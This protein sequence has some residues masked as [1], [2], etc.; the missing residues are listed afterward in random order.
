MGKTTARTSF[1]PEATVTERAHA[2]QGSLVR[3]RH[4]C[5]AG[6]AVQGGGADGRSA[7]TRSNAADAPTPAPHPP[8]GHT[9]YTL[10]EEGL[11][12][13]Q[14]QT[15]E[16]SAAEALRESFTPTAGPRRQLF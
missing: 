4:L 12:V 2:E 13:E 5:R 10:N 14:R 3:Q 9:V 11:I 15:W 7:H 8:T 6:R 1:I 16:K